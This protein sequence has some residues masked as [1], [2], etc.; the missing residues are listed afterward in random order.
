MK[1]LRGILVALIVAFLLTSL[2]YI[3][4]SLPVDSFKELHTIFIFTL[5]F[6]FFYPV[7]TL[8]SDD[9]RMN[10]R[11][12]FFVFGYI[13]GF[14]C[15]FGHLCH[16]NMTHHTNDFI[17]IAVDKQTRRPVNGVEIEAQ[18]IGVSKKTI[19]GGL[20]FFEIDS[21]RKKITLRLK[22]TT[23]YRLS[24]GFKTYTIE[25]RSKPVRLKLIKM[26]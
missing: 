7:N 4:P 12:G 13:M 14:L 9:E 22:N 5:S 23:N 20:V 18:E 8:F 25:K 6:L 1:I 15:L 3:V 17:V 24:D 2:K 16:H 10:L 11:G 26:K 21:N 19:F